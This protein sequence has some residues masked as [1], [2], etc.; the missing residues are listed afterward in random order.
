M[1]FHLVKCVWGVDLYLK[2]VYLKIE[3]MVHEC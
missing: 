1:I 3:V 2:G